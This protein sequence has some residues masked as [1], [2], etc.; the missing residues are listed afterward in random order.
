MKSVV[1]HSVRKSSPQLT[2]VLSWPPLNHINRWAPN[3]KIEGVGGGGGGGGWGGDTVAGGQDYMRLKV[4]PGQAV[5]T[6]D[7]TDRLGD[8]VLSPRHKLNYVMATVS[9]GMAGRASLPRNSLF[10]YHEQ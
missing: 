10:Y 3:R 9:A 1:Q 6:Q 7:N 8:A 5:G 4:D 2:G